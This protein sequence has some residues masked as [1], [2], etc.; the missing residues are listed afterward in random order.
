V[1][2]RPQGLTTTA[3]RRLSIE[4]HAAILEAL[5][6]HDANRAEQLVRDHLDAVGEMIRDAATGSDRA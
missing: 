4:H 1:R 2:Y 6:A 5:R 3:N